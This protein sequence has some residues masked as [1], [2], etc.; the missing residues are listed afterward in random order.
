MAQLSRVLAG[1]L[2]A[3][4]LA[5]PAAAEKRVAL[6]IGNSAYQHA[7]ALASPKTDAEGM[8]AALKGLGFE[9]L[10]GTDLDKPAMERLLRDFAQKIAGTDV[11]LVFYAGQALQVHGRNYLVPIDGKLERESDLAL[12]AV[13]LDLVQQ[14]MQQERRA[15]VMIL[16][17]CRDN[18]F[19][20]LLWISSS[21]AQGSSRFDFHQAARDCGTGTTPSR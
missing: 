19:L 18:G 10:A 2:L 17:S 5:A 7:P 8:A 12:H 13:S 3:F 20:S 21:S 14:P 6:V 15:N 4:V 11:A 9:V 16:G 1:L